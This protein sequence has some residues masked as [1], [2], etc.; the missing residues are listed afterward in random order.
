[1]DQEPAGLASGSDFESDGELSAGQKSSTW[2]PAPDN[3]RRCRFCVCLTINGLFQPGQVY[4]KTGFVSTWVNKHYEHHASLEDLEQSA[5]LGYD[6]CHFMI[7]YTKRARFCET[8]F[9]EGGVSVD[10]DLVI[11]EY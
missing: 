1:M 3:S 10:D 5:E 8:E 7:E 11:E 6:F 9:R 2:L 4:F